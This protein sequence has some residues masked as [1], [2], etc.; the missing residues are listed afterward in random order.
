MQMRHGWTARTKRSA[1]LATTALLTGCVSTGLNYDN[2]KS[3]EF[4]GSVV[5]IWVGEGGPSGD[6]N[7]LF[8]PDPDK[9]LT[10][11]RRDPKAPGAV[12]K[13]SIM[14]TDGGSIPKLA[15]A[16]RGF[17]PWGYAPAY[18]I[19]DWLFVAQHCIRDR[20]PAPRYQ[21]LKDVTFEESAKII[22][23]AIHTLVDANQVK[24]NDTAAS[25]ITAAVG[26]DIARKRWEADGACA[27]S[28]VSAEDLALANRLVPG[29][30]DVQFKQMR[31]QIPQ[32]KIGQSRII[33]RVSF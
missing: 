21:R 1:C 27:E 28:K 16:F 9:P 22:G 3:G 24:E 30:T 26:T 13:P 31:R 20:D 23:E 10:F 2:L 4:S 19:H 15:Q 14:Y 11:R 25:L 8:V 17:S 5:V 7:F 33:A 32:A 12:I 29:S 6:G 18:M